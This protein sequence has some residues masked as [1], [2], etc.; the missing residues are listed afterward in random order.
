M[1]QF[2]TTIPP[3]TPW[4]KTRV[5]IVFLFI[6]GIVGLLVLAIGTMAGYYTWQIKQGKGGEL[7]KQFQSSAFTLQP[8]YEYAAL[9]VEDVS[10]YIRSHNPVLGIAE[11]PITIV[12]F[13]DFECPFCQRAYPIFA[14][15]TAQY[16]PAVRVVFKHFPIESIHPR[17]NGAALAAACAHEQGKFWEYYNVLFEQKTLGAPQLEQYADSIGLQSAQFTN[18]IETRRY[19]AKIEQDIADGL[20]L[21]VRGTPTYFL[22][23]T[24][25]EGVTSLETWNTLILDHLKQLP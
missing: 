22:N 14:Q 24:K 19:A 18:C 15:M 9:A 20:D 13:I 8:D 5:G 23:N 21:G 10:P 6:L 25:V 7:A 2:Q 4:Y 17:A 11:A 12:A 1:D 3:K 16:D